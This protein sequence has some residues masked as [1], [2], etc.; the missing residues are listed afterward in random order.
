MLAQGQL[1]E[2]ASDLVATLPHLNCDQFTRHC[3]GFTSNQRGSIDS[4]EKVMVTDACLGDRL[5]N[6]WYFQPIRLSIRSCFITPAR[7]Q[8]PSLVGLCNST[9][10]RASKFIPTQF[11]RTT[12]QLRSCES[13]VVPKPPNSGCCTAYM[14]RNIALCLASY[15]HALA[16]HLR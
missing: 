11:E 10:H 12:S 15:L 9:S 16:D 3:C 6:E 7:D 1:P 5:S 8:L 2:P 14:L 4:A 13:S